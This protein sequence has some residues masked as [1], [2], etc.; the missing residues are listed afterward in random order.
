VTVKISKSGSLAIVIM[1]NPPVNAIGKSTREGLLAAVEKLNQDGLIDFVVLTGEGKIFAAGADARE[2]DLPL[3]EPH[4]PDVALAIENSSTPWVAAI[5]GAALGGGLE[6]ALACRFRVST[7]DANLGLP[8][9]TL[10]IVPGAGGT[11]RLPRLI[12]MADALEMIS[13]GR[14]VSGE[15][16][17]KLGLVDVVD[18]NPLA[19]CKQ[20][21]LEAIMHKK[22]VSQMENPADDPDAIESAKST[23]NKRSRLQIAPPIAI[24]LVEQTATLDFA[25]GLKREREQFLKLRV[26]SQAKAL[27][28][29]FFSQRDTKPQASIA[30]AQPTDIKNAVVVGGGNMGAAIA[31]AMDG[32]GISVTIIETDHESV[33]RASANIG[34]LVDGALK[35]GKITSDKANE[36]KERIKIVA[37]YENLPRAQLAIE[38]AFEDMSVKKAVFQQLEKV[39]PSDAILASNTSYLN[40]DEI[41]ASTSD[42]SRVVGL[43]FFSP[44]HIMKL[45]EIVRGK[46]TQDTALA[47]AY[48]L[49]KRLSKIPVLSGVCDGFIGNRLLSRYREIA[50][51]IMMDG[52]MPWQID[53]AMVDFGYAMGPYETQDLSGL[54]IAYANRKRNAET[55]DPN[56]RYIPI[57]DV[58]VERGRLGRKTH[59]GWYHYSTETGQTPDKEVEKIIKDEARKANIKRRDFSDQE[60]QNRL[61]T[62]LINEASAILEEGIAQ[63][64]KDIDLVLVHGYGFPRWRGGPLFYAD[65][66]GADTVVANIREYEKEDPVIW[67]PN[68]LLV[69][70]AEKGIPFHHRESQG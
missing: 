18:E 48:A 53:K 41:A 12:G 61:M 59:A 34:T 68:P 36:Q 65:E 56:R 23:A 6:L 9:V 10:G 5:N 42:A 20:L 54:E 49:A 11:Q 67:K 16:A 51:T 45:L 3:S 2:F 17:R 66:I 24:E 7:R 15:Q 1:D 50:D 31:Y 43:H 26:S 70:L 14:P 8:E 62:A 46:K 19:F 57:A 40:L 13:S 69:S 29:A 22:P 44:A 33:T 55:R 28:Y 30:K 37:G 52:A 60:I 64:A 21:A 47:T 32:A 4:L 63:S 27:R 39:L 35:R 25:Q 38:A 58:L